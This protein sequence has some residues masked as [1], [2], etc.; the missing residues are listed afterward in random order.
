[1]TDRSALAAIRRGCVRL[2]AVATASLLLALTTLMFLVEAPPVVTWF[3]ASAALAGLCYAV[4]L[5][6]AL[7]ES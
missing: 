2:G 5:V 1:M 7:C 6:A 3:I 4:A